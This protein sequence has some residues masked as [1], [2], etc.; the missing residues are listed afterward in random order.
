[1]LV[2]ASHDD[3]EFRFESCTAPIGCNRPCDPRPRERCNGCQGSWPASAITSSTPSETLKGF[4]HLT[5][6]ID[7]TP[8]A[9]NAPTAPLHTQPRSIGWGKLAA[10]KDRLWTGKWNAGWILPDDAV[11]IVA[12]AP[13]KGSTDPG[14]PLRRLE[15]SESSAFAP[16]QRLFRQLNHLTD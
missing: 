9:L 16:Q 2:A 8:G 15:A 14:P 11:V 13:E 1:M 10:P 5:P 3:D 4:L 12:K 7:E 6:T